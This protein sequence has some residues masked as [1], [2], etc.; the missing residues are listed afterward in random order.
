MSSSLSWGES[1]LLSGFEVGSLADR[2]VLRAPHSQLLLGSSTPACSSSCFTVFGSA[3]PR[4]SCCIYRGLPGYCDGGAVEVVIVDF[5]VSLTRAARSIQ[6]QISRLATL[7]CGTLVPWLTS[8]G[9]CLKSHS[10]IRSA[11]RFGRQKSWATVLEVAHG[12]TARC[13]CVPTCWQLSQRSA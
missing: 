4:T 10:S 6:R 3:R 12:L 5:A 2:K 11:V 7:H 9:L 8:H 1:R 13:T